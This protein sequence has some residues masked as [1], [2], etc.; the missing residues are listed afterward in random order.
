MNISNSSIH[1]GNAD[2]FKFIEARPG[3]TMILMPDAPYYTIVAVSNDFLTTSGRQREE[4]IGKSHFAIFPENPADPSIGVHS[5]RNSFDY[6]VQ[7]KTSHSLPLVRYDIPDGKGGFLEKYWKSTNAPVLDEKGDVEYVIHT[8]EDVTAQEKAAQRETAFRDMEKAFRL[9]M[10]A[11]FVVGLVVGENHVLELANE[12]AYKLWGK[13]PEILGKPLLEAIPEFGGQGIE[14]LFEQVKSTGKSFYSKATPVVSMP[15]GK[16]ETHY[17]DL[18]YQPYYHEGSDAPTGV[19]TISHDVTELKKAEEEAAQFKFIADNARDP[20]ILMREDGTFAYLNKKALEAWGY[21]EDE[22]RHIRVPDVDPIYQEA[23]FTAVFKRTQKEIIPQFESVHKRKDGHVYPV[24]VNMVGLSF[25]GEPL[26][27]AVARDITERKKM[28]Q[29]IRESE[30]MLQKKVEE[31]TAELEAKNDELRRSNQNLEEFAHAASHDLKEP[32]RKISFFTNQLKDQLADRLSEKEAFVFSRIENASQ[33]MTK[34]IDDLL[35]YSHV[36]QRPHQT[37]NIDLNKKVQNVLEDLELDIAQK[38]ADI[39]VGKLPV[40]QGYRRQ[41][42]QMFQNLI[43]NALK[44]SK[45][46]VPPVIDIMA[47]EVFESGKRYHLIEVKDNG[48]GFESE[49]ADKIFQMFTRLHSKAEYSGTGVGLSIVRKVVEN[50][51]GFI[52]VESTPD[53]GSTFTV[54]LPAHDGRDL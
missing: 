30:G 27:F 18:I 19:F 9:F 43:S 47:G 28:E 24:E 15:G 25:R 22:A 52:R 29:A 13:G 42:Q 54:L 36:S 17:F 10:H 41:L 35:L 46:N 14:E 23:E 8:S 32:I 16:K 12:A 7:N 21:T 49:Y 20:F 40:V 5:L 48:I 11:P 2:E 31:R 33:R 34:L 1:T 50:H 6:I 4:V 53:E 45:T 3:I 39:H 37:E 51:N 26:M 44:Y 38:Q